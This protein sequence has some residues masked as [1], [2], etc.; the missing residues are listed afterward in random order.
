MSKHNLIH[1]AFQGPDWLCFGEEILLGDVSKKARLM[2]AY[3][4]RPLSRV[5]QVEQ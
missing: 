3:S 2:D 4:K 5:D 1:P